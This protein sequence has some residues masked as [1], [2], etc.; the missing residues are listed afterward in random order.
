[1]VIKMNNYAKLSSKKY[2]LSEI[3]GKKQANKPQSAKVLDYKSLIVESYV[4]ID[5]SLE[6][7]LYSKQFEEKL[8]QLINRYSVLSLSEK[9]KVYDSIYS[10]WK[11]MR[12]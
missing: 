8:R 10:V 11:K 5:K 2:K 12:W 3:K 6:E 4:L 7:R 1:M 9:S